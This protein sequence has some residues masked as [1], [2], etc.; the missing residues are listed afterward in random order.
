MLL[1]SLLFWGWQCDFLVYAVPMALLLELSRYITFRVDL[2]DDEFNHIADL[3]SILFMVVAI[4]VF[5]TRSYHGIFNILSLL[6]F[7]F[8]L[9]ILSQL[10]SRQGYIR[11]SAIFISLRRMDMDHE[12]G[13]GETLDLSYPYFFLCILSASAGNSSPDFFYA[14]MVLLI[15]WALVALKPVHT[16]SYVLAA[17]LLVTASAGY[18]GQ[19]GLQKLQSMV[20]NT[21]LVW[22]DRFMWRSRD[23]NRTSTAIGTLGKLKLSERIM[24]RVN[25][26]DPHFVPPM[27]LREASYTNY[28]YGVWTNFQNT[29]QLVDPTLDGK[30]WIINPGQ[31]EKRKFSIGFHMDDDTAIVPV[32]VHLAS[33]F[34]IQAT[35]IE[36]SAYDSIRMEYKPG[37][38]HYDVYSG[39][40][41]VSSAEP[42]KDELE[43]PG[44]YR[45]ELDTLSGQLG[46]DPGNP[47][48]TVQAVKDFFSANFSYSL[49][50]KQRYPRG[51]Y[52]SKFLF[53]T[54]QGHCEYFATATALLLRAAGIPSRYVVGYSIQE[55]SELE[56]R[57]I[58][59]ASHAHSWVE[60]FVNGK[61][62]IIDTTPSVWTEIQEEDVPAIRPLIDLWSWISYMLV[63]D[64]TEDQSSNRT[65]IMV[66]ILV[67]V[68]LLFLWRIIRE[69]SYSR[70]QLQRTRTGK[71]F[72]QGQDSVFYHLYQLLETRFGKKPDGMTLVN[73]ANILSHQ[74]Q[75]D[76]IHLLRIIRSHYRYR[77]D[78]DGISEMEK[79]ALTADVDN[80]I[81]DFKP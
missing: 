37:W 17:L 35:Q 22:F 59:R 51:K 74:Y 67:P 20:E 32:P 61:W 30:K 70:K 1:S 27:L 53:E 68:L 34:N 63:A 12:T 56:N 4:Y 78:P 58:A 28:G 65:T 15:S 72:R 14:G 31:V 60:A 45:D 23:P 5:M 73:W 24:V 66:W 44:M 13:A 10:Y 41:P 47:E 26:K 25:T 18:A 16:K 75:L 79:E 49:T 46:L 33:I 77:F 36:A 54:R 29:F 69:K 43:I 71:S 8:Y 64:D 2:R 40:N 76:S 55:Y 62:E 42:G 19:A 3:S 48:Q 52:L 9:L 7:L 11:A 57:Y 80:M 39:D 21:A 50:Q 81:A 38:I 6:P